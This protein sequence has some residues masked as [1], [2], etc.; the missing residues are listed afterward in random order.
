M[1][2]IFLALVCLWTLPQARAAVNLLDKDQWKIDFGGFAEFDSFYDTRKS[3]TETIGN[4][5]VARPN[6][7]KGRTQ[8]SVRNSR[9]SFNVMAPPVENWKAR[10]YFELD[11]L[12][13][14]SAPPTQSEA[15]FFNNPTMRV[16]HAYLSTENQGWQ[17]L[18]GQTWAVLGWQPYYFMPTLQVAPIPAMLYSRTTQ[19]RVVKSM[20]VSDSTTMQVAAGAMRPPQRDGQYPGLEGG[21]RIAFNDRKGAFTGGATGSH[22]PQPLSLGLS[23]TARNFEIPANAT[24]GTDNPQGKIAS[25]FA[26]NLLLPVL[27]SSDGKDTSNNLVLGGEYTMGSGYG[28]HFSGWSGNQNSPLSG[29]TTAPDKNVNLDAGI[30]G[31]DAF[32]NFVLI[33]LRTFNVYMQYH[34][35]ESTHTWISGGYSDLRSSNMS[36]VAINKTGAT[37]YDRES[38]YFGN[39]AHDFTDQVRA[40]FEFAR[41]TTNY[42]DGVN[43]GAN[44]FQI[45]SWFIF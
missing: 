5:P 7:E 30:G 38:S 41:I 22:K 2:T 13:F 17:I 25:G 12:G 29:A 45:S 3:F 6:G 44:R 19:V 28:D 15:A 34:L 14:D 18:T 42:V 43:V 40:G 37:A 26:A 20:D 39:I 9:L 24:T 31:F 23:G 32:G 10:G 4:T 36:S 16:R 8:F 35:P 33:K 27:A 21:L 1:K 11:F